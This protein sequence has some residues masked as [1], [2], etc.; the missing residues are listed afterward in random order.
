M[1]EGSQNENMKVVASGMSL[2]SVAR[3]ALQV[4]LLESITHKRE[5]GGMIYLENGTYKA[6]KARTSFEA[7]RVDVGVHDPPNHGC[8]AGTQPV[9][10]Y[11]T[12][13]AASVGGFKGAY[14]EFSPEDM[15]VVRDN[16]LK[17]AYLGTLD[18]SFLRWDLGMAKPRELRP[19]LRNTDG[20]NY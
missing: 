2:D 9:A 15:D 16:G 14:N 20:R 3:T 19:R 1:D 4:I 8:P 12:H 6:L 5:Y 11:H 7:A 13:T 10:Y 18:G 17:S